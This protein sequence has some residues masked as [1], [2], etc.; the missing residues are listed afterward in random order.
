VSAIPRKLR[1]AVVARAGGCCEYCLLH[2]LGQVSRFP[3]DHSLPRSQ[4][5][6]TILANLALQLD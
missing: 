2:P 5:G 4:G 1:L 3:I 6:R